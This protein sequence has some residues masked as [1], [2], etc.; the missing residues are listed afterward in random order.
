MFVRNLHKVGI[1]RRQINVKI[2]TQPTLGGRSNFEYAIES[3]NLLLRFGK[4]TTFL[5]IK[6]E[7]LKTL[8]TK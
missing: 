4:M 6:Q 2:H 1:S 5:K 3:E 8:Y 7:L